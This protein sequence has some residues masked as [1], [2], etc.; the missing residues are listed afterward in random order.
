MSNNQSN[1]KSQNIDELYRLLDEGKNA[2]E[3]G[4]KRPLTDVMK[5]IK[6]EIINGQISN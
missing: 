5:D 6:Q 3:T 4:K 2:I 1:K